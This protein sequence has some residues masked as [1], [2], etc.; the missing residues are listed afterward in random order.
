MM[1]GMMATIP[2]TSSG[3]PPVPLPWLV[4]PEYPSNRKATARKATP[5]SAER[6]TCLGAEGR[7]ESAA[8]TESLVTGAGRSCSAQVRGD[9]GQNDGRDDHNPGKGKDPDHVVGTLFECR[10][11]GHPENQ[12]EHSA[13]KGPDDTDDDPVCSHNERH[14]LVRGANRRQHAQ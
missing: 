13:D 8:I 4:P 5:G 14:V 10:S 2:S 6:W 9:Q 1:A 7:P 11:V 12:T 3:V